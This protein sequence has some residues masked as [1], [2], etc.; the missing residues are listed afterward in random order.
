V[1]L[2]MLQ[3]LLGLLFLPAI[4]ILLISIPFKGTFI[5]VVSGQAVPL[6]PLTG[7]NATLNSGISKF[8]NCIEKEVKASKNVNDDPYFKSEPTKAEVFKCYNMI[9]KES[10]Q[11]S[12]S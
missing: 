9:F 4:F 1:V 6:I 7:G 11:E 2:H 10:E 8:Y 3:Q 12:V 5:N